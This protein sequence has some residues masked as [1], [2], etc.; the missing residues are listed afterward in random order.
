ME[1][2]S[3][4]KANWICEKKLPLIPGNLEPNGVTIN[5]CVPLIFESYCKLFHPF[6]INVNESDIL[7]PDKVYKQET[8]E[9]DLHKQ[10][11]KKKQ[12]HESQNLKFVDWQFVAQKYGLIFHKE[13]SIQAFNEKFKKIGWPKN[14]WSPRE[15]YLPRPLLKKLLS[16]LKKETDNDIV[17]VYQIPPNSIMKG[18][19]FQ[20]LIKCTFEEV[21]SYFDEDFIG[22]LYP[23]DESWI[24]STDTDLHFTIIGGTKKLI[25]AIVNSNLEAIECGPTTRVDNYSDKLNKVS[26]I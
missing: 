13:I 10:Y 4:E 26:R 7:I 5:H 22:Y 24:G 3:V 1:R 14:L 25:G 8:A 23:E 19:K 9:L 17:F 6:E 18:E 15:G 20:D 2:L 11:Q 16:I 21:L 12:E